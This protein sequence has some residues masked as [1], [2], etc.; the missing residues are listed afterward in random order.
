MKT[1]RVRL[2]LWVCP[3]SHQWVQGAQSLNLGP[4][5]TRVFQTQSGAGCTRMTKVLQEPHGCTRQ[6]LPSTLHT[7]PASHTPSHHAVSSPHTPSL[8]LPPRLSQPRSKSA[9]ILP[10]S[11]LFNLSVHWFSPLKKAK[12]SQPMIQQSHPQAYI[13]KKAK[14]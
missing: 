12:H 2:R 3:A 14:T 1:R 13:Q 8:K 5:P 7:H 6:A 9:N 10:W 11:K 4:P